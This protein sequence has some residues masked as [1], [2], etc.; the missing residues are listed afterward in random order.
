MPR[1]ERQ[2]EVSSIRV[3]FLKHFQEKKLLTLWFIG[4]RTSSPR[5]TAATSESSMIHGKGKKED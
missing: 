2:L 4:N 5:D 3:D 1:F